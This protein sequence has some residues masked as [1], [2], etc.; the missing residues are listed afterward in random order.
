MRNKAAVCRPPGNHSPLGSSV[1]PC[2]LTPHSESPRLCSA[3]WVLEMDL[4]FVT[5]H[6]LQQVCWP[7]HSSPLWMCPR[8]STSCPALLLAPARPHCHLIPWHPKQSEDGVFFPGR[9]GLTQ[10]DPQKS[11]ADSKGSSKIPHVANRGH[12]YPKTAL[13]SL[14]PILLVT[15]H[16]QGSHQA[17]F[18]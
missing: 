6:G 15:L 9:V 5:V 4:N 14:G 12:S 10:R 11:P 13:G 2:L 7:Q 18:R 17:S 16:S 3:P 1:S 8:R